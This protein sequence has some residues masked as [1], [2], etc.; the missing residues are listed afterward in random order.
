MHVPT[1]TMSLPRFNM[2]GIFVFPCLNFSSWNHEIVVRRRDGRSRFCLIDKLRC[3]CPFCTEWIVMRGGSCATAINWPSYGQSGDKGVVSGRTRRNQHAQSG[4]H[5]RAT[6]PSGFGPE[7]S[8]STS[9]FFDPC[10]FH[11]LRR[12]LLFRLVMSSS[13]SLSG[14]RAVDS[15]RA[16]DGSRN[17][18]SKSIGLC[19]LQK[20]QWRS[21]GVVTCIRK[22]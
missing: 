12:S 22:A 17:E 20:M 15:R 9:H 19:I 3:S 8:T 21:E 7:A 2:S 11:R 5:V 6:I 1:R 16:A 4:L 14:H 18:A 10:R 13:R